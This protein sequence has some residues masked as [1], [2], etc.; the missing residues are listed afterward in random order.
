MYANYERMTIEMTK[1]ES[2]AAGKINTE[3]YMELKELRTQNPTFRIV[4]KTMP[5]LVI[6]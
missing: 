3:E 5:S 1:S 2:K 6:C 4:I